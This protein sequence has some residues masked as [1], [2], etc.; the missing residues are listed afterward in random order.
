MWLIA[1]VPHSG[2]PYVQISFIIVEVIRCI[3]RENAWIK[4]KVQY[5][6]I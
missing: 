5:T 2:I 1:A 6:Y 4:C 3:K